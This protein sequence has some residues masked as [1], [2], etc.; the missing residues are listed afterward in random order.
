[1]LN[2]H[3][4]WQLTRLRSQSLSRQ[5]CWNARMSSYPFTTQ[6]AVLLTR[7][8]PV[9]AGAFAFP[10]KSSTVSF[11]SHRSQPTDKVMFIYSGWLWLW[12]AGGGWPALPHLRAWG[13]PAAGGWYRA[14]TG[15]EEQGHWAWPP[16]YTRGRT[17]FCHAQGLH[18]TKVPTQTRMIIKF[19]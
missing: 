3:R 4:S 6:T 8:L 17:R 1:M 13:Q 12:Y 2:C 11:A 15:W 10:A 18:N 14:Q 16:V 5:H 9:L 19:V 7:V